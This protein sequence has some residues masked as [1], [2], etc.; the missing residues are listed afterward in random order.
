LRR[1]AGS[2]SYFRI[3]WRIVARLRSVCWAISRSDSPAAKR[4]SNSSFDTAPFDLCF[5]ARTASSPCFF[6]PV[7]DR[8]F[9]LAD[10]LADRFERHSLSQTLFEELSLHSCIFSSDADR[11]M[12]M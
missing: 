12:R 2:S 10:S 4:R 7:A 1:G 11:K 3:Q 9:V 8:R 6:Q 5:S